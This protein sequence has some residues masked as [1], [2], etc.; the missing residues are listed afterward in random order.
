MQQTWHFTE[1]HQTLNPSAEASA[2]NSR[3]AKL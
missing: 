2:F 1:V 3:D